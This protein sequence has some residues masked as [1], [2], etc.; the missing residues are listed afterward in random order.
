MLGWLLALLATL[1]AIFWL[2][3]GTD[4]TSTPIEGGQLLYVGG[5]AAL[6]LLYMSSLGSDYRGRALKALSHAAVWLVL[7]LILVAGYAYREEF[8]SVAYRIA[9]EVLPAGQVIVIDN[10][11]SG[12]RSVR[13]RR[14]DS[15]HFTVRAE[16]NGQAMRLLVDTGASA[17]VLKVSDAKRIGI[18]TGA[19]NYSVPVQT[20]NGRTFSAPI[21][22]RSV[23][24]GPIV[25]NN[26][27]ALIAK[28]G[29]LN[30]SLL[31]MSFLKRL[32][33]Y[34]FTGDFL[35]IRG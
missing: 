15:G 3:G 13:I 6:L 1:V 31:G 16:V 32:R 23:A 10:G 33:S 18:D 30:E 4:G 11:A 34:E 28:P 19:L 9:G 17:V 5:L 8:K 35:T 26:I 21:R 29:S 27:E 2:L 7:G 25:L 24:I 20:A 22:L 12:E 14:Q